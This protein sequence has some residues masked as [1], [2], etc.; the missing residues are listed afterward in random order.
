ME[1]ILISSKAV[2]VEDDRALVIQ[3]KNGKL[4][5]SPEKKKGRGRPKGRTNRPKVAKELDLDKGS[6]TAKRKYKAMKPDP[7]LMFGTSQVPP[8]P[9]MR[10]EGSTSAMGEDDQVPASEVLAEKTAE[11][12][13]STSAAS[14]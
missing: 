8:I 3:H 4:W 12:E 7:N 13:S 14:Q 1:E 2:S 5:V 6:G 11:V 9:A 10:G